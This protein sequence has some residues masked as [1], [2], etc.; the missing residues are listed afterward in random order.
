MKWLINTQEANQRLSSFLRQKL[1]SDYSS[2]W[3]KKQLDEGMV[4]LNGS[5]ERF[6]K[7]NVRAG[8]R[9]ELKTQEKKS[10]TCEQQRIL[11]E[12]DALFV[13]DKP[14][15]CRVVEDLLPALKKRVP[16]L[17]AVHRLDKETTGVVLFAKNEM[18]ARQLER[19]FL[20]RQVHKEYVAIVAGEV[21]SAH[22]TIKSS[23]VRQGTSM[24]WKALLAPH[25]GLYA[26]MSW[27]LLSRS[28]K[29]AVVRCLPITGR[30]HQI[31]V[32]LQSIGHPIIGDRL[33]AYAPWSTL[34]PRLML[35]ARQLEILFDGSSY[36]WVAPIPLDFKKTL[37]QLR[38]KVGRG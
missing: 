38:L 6:S 15:G 23:L 8:D 17:I 14:S 11:F 7:T 24:R 12:S 5:I 1:S 3:I 22:G 18:C 29:A 27:Q 13:Y 4:L 16:S 34:A 19:A 25:P 33:Y 31:R 30:T 10:L 2:Q 9:I 32:Q 37:E 35:H 26:E 20:E 21:P 36:R 28:S